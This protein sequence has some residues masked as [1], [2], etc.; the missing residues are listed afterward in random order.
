MN[1]VF[2]NYV[3]SDK[4]LHV[5]IIGGRKYSE[6]IRQLFI[7]ILFI[8]LVLWLFQVLTVF[9]ITSAKYCGVLL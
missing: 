7:T 1:L 8:C 6:Q 9:G 5:F 4:S 3:V 2:Q